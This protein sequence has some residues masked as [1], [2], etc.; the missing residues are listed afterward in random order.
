VRQFLC[1]QRVGPIGMAEEKDADER[2]AEHAAGWSVA[3]LGPIPLQLRPSNG[4]ARA[5]E[6]PAGQWCRDNRVVPPRGSFQ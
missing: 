3:P 6:R 1:A 5:A 4:Q 2:E